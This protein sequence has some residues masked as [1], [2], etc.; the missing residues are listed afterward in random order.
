MAQNISLLL[1]SAIL[2]ISAITDI[3]YMKIPNW[4]TFPAIIAGILLSG[5]PLSTVSY[6]RIL[7]IAIFFLL[8]GTN[9]LGGSGDVKL[10]MAIIALQGVYRAFLMIAIGA[11]SMMGFCLVTNRGETAFSIKS[12][13]NTAKYR[14]NMLYHSRKYP[15]APFLTAGYFLSFLIDKGGLP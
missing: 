1:S 8:Y 10:M 3:K 12:I 6:I 2:I 5:F 13:L 7:W 14:M 11:F 15:F 9:V 4:L